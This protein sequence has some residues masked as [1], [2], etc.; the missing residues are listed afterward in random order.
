MVSRDRLAVGMSLTLLLLPF[1]PASGII[2]KV[3]FVVA[4]R[5]LY[6]PSLGSCLLVTIGMRRTARLI[7]SQVAIH[8]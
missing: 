8:V 1:L 3:G 2:F 7:Q 5:V 6:M 4:E